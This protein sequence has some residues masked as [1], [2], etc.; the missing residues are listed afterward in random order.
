MR[1]SSIERYL[2]QGASRLGGEAKKLTGR[3]N[4]TDRLVLWHWPII[5]FVETKADGEEPRRG[6]LREH[7]RLRARGYSVFVLASKTAVDEYLKLR[8]TKCKAS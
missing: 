8:G 1:E 5:D 3:R 6:Q 2:V 7:A 4:D